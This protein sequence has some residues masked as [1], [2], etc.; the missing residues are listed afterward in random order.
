VYVYTSRANPLHWQ[1][2]CQIIGHPELIGDPRY[3]TSAARVE[4]E[5][6][7]DAMIAAW[8]RQRTKHEAMQVMGAAGIPA[9]AVLDTKELQNDPTFEQR[10]IMQVVQHPTNGSVKLPGWPVRHN[11]IPPK[12]LPAPLLGQ[13][14]AEVLSTWLGIDDK[15]VQKLRTAGVV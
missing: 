4:R 10:G 11:G 9:G 12:V 3:E 8:T 13:H 1:R 6:E 2:L 15:Q 14:T 5:P 7:I